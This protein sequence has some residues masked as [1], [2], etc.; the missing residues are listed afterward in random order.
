[1]A[2]DFQKGIRL[3]LIIN[4]PAAAGLALLSGPIV[5]L[6][7]RHGQVTP[8]EAH[9]MGFLLAVMA[10]GCPSSRS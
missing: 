1:M 8:D 5:S 4:V 9:S 2:T 10:I 7:F 3:I 6:L